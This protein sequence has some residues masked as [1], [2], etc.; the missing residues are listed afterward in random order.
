MVEVKYDGQK[1][2]FQGKDKVIYIAH[3]VDK[4]T[5]LERADFEKMKP[6][7]KDSILGFPNKVIR[8]LYKKEREEKQNLDK[9]IDKMTS[10]VTFGVIPEF[11]FEVVKNAGLNRQ[12]MIKHI[13][14]LNITFI[15]LGY[16]TKKPS[17]YKNLLDKYFPEKDFEKKVE[18]INKLMIDIEQNL[19]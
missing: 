13:E 6:L 5:L 15:N 3:G 7:E 16:K 11:E 2:I 10:N 19:E 18:R 9:K 17:Y 1:L 4:L 14:S 12:D 8:E